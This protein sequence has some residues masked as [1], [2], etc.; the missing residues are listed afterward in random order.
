MK[1]L[2]Y[3]VL[4]TLLPL[5]VLLVLLYR[6]RLK[7]FSTNVK[8]IVA[9]CYFVVTSTAALVSSYMSLTGISEKGIRCGTGAV[10]FLF[11]GAIIFALGVIFLFHDNNKSAKN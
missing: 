7:N 5:L 8:A 1:T 2:V 3:P 4:L 9:V 10:A 6:W 11:L